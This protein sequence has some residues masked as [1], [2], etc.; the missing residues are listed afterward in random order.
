MLALI[1]SVRPLLPS[2][3]GTAWPLFLSFACF[4]KC[5]QKHGAWDAAAVGDW[6]VAGRVSAETERGR[7]VVITH[8]ATAPAER[9]QV[10]PSIEPRRPENRRATADERAG[11]E[12]EKSTSR[13]VETE[14]DRASASLVCVALINLDSIGLPRASHGRFRPRRLAAQAS[15]TTEQN[16][17][18][19]SPI[20]DHAA[21]LHTR[22]NKQTNSRADD[23]GLFRPHRFP[24][25]P[26]P[27][28]GWWD[29]I[30]L[31]RV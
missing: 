21:H 30:V 20:M 31:C 18:T 28:P 9:R 5:R 3:K 26:P 27:P 23:P 15:H 17:N 12:R 11:K 10:T 7:G 2:Q 29:Q 13:T 22:S 1:S 25:F 24:P 14:R 19:R 16:K 8:P 4:R 6:C